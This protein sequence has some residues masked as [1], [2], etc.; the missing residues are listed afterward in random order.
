[1]IS[2]QSKESKLD[3]NSDFMYDIYCG[4]WMN[5]LASNCFLVY[6]CIQKCMYFFWAERRRN[7]LQNIS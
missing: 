7:Y 1:M 6:T 4:T 2:V 3:A 5:G